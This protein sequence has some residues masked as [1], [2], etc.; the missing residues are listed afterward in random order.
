MKKIIIILFL[1]FCGATF[2]LQELE[3]LTSAL[4]ELS[5][6][7][8]VQ[9][10]Q[11][12]IGYNWTGSPLEKVG[13]IL[14]NNTGQTVYISVL[15]PSRAV[16][17]N[18]DIYAVENN[19]AKPIALDITQKTE[20]K[21]FE[22]STGTKLIK[23]YEFSQKKTIFVV[24]DSAYTVKPTPSF[25]PFVIA[26]NQYFAVTSN[27]V[28]T[29]EIRSVPVVFAEKTDNK[30]CEDLKN[31]QSLRFKKSLQNF[32]EDELDRL[33]SY[34]VIQIINDKKSPF[35][36]S[37]L[38][39]EL[40]P[41]FMVDVESEMKPAHLK[42]FGLQNNYTEKDLDAAWRKIQ[43]ELHPD[44]FSKDCALI[45]KAIRTIA[46]KVFDDLKKYATPEAKKLPGK[47]CVFF[48][49]SPIYFDGK[50]YK[51]GK[52]FNLGDEKY[53]TIDDKIRLINSF[54]HPS[55][56]FPYTANYFN[57]VKAEKK[58]LES[59]FMREQK[60]F[61]E[62]KRQA[63][64]RKEKISESQIK[65]HNNRI[66]EI[67]KNEQR[68]YLFYNEALLKN[69]TA[70]FG[71]YNVDDINKRYEYF[72][73]MLT[74]PENVRE[75]EHLAR[76]PFSYITDLYNFLMGYVQAADKNKYMNED[77]IPSDL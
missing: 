39:I 31:I 32:T 55:F 16:G 21:I 5:R 61:L 18:N 24:I 58:R 71:N 64:N 4:Q 45:L 70:L 47:Y 41:L 36:W 74:D 7:I 54:F 8:P 67:E 29:S 22:D 68:Q 42:W 30:K 52:E 23:K 27:N 38:H 2:A 12:V 56:N 73:K 1:S 35:S 9:K 53:C 25:P 19:S 26:A 43:Q 15:N 59:E 46:G 14:V 75:C 37:K 34:D 72:K 3:N 28:K 69:A 63:E 62:F 66:S 33:D 50:E 40:P 6:K 10:T 60:A 76:I 13:F 20:L 49:G 77:R 51:L 48:Q 17:K 65:A 11:P 44:K 57:T